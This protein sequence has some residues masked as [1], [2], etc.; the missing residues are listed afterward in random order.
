MHQFFLKID[1]THLPRPGE[2][3]TLDSEESH[4]LFTVLRGGRGS[5]VDLVDGF[6]HRWTGSP[7]EKDGGLARIEILS[8]DSEVEEVQE[9]RLVLAC[10][11]VKGKRF[12]WALE[13][14]VEA[15]VHEIVPLIT[16]HGVVDPRAGKK[17]RWQTLL[18]T[19]VK[20]CGRSWLPVLAEPMP[21]G[22]WLETRS[23]GPLLFGDVGEAEN[24]TPYWT[25]L[26]AGDFSECPASLTM[27][28]GPEGGWSPSERILLAEADGVP[29]GLGPHVLRTETAAVVG[30]AVLQ[31]LRRK[32]QDRH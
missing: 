11:V 7:Q 13:K 32:Y 1:P 27:S 17:G 8:M 4:H 5:T 14:A 23:A 22:R 9:P 15:G 28:I 29:L 26:L 3:V 19:A 2:I 12:E 25:S 18:T 20:Q 31:A 21:L 16:E 10:A 24:Q 30:L 6:G